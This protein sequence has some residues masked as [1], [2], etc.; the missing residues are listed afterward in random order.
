MMYNIETF[1]QWH[2]SFQILESL[3]VNR[4]ELLCTYLKL[5]PIRWQLLENERKQI[6]TFTC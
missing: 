2:L 4:I 3:T 5:N 6:E 1:C